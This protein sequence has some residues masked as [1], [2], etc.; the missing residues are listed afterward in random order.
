MKFFNKYFFIGFGCGAIF[1]FVCE[2][3]FALYAIMMV[4]H[5]MRSY[6]EK[7]E[8]P[9]EIEADAPQADYGFA[10][11]DLQG[12]FMLVDT[13]KGK[14][15]FMNIW[16]TCDPFSRID[17]SSIQ[18]LYDKM[19][20]RKDVV[21]LIMTDEDLPTVQK[22]MKKNKYTFPVYLYKEKS[23]PD[24]FRANAVPMTFIIAP[25]GKIAFKDSGDIKWDDE[26]VFAFLDKLSGQGSV[27]TTSQSTSTSTSL[28]PIKV[29]AN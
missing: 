24:V 8:L 17:M 12:H 1:V 29:Q 9:L 22:F 18:K 23:L 5:Q 11:K 2:M 7:P 14:V 4:N 19:K 21:F 27:S 3:L 13:L 10:V 20:N 26:E 25:D 28:A 6:L 16:A 15:L